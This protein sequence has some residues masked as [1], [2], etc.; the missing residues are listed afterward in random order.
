MIEIT[1]ESGEKTEIE[2]RTG[3]ERK[4]GIERRTGNGKK[5]GRDVKRGTEIG[6]K[7]AT[8]YLT[9]MIGGKVK[10]IP[11]TQRGG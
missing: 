6:W 9:K 8:K 4:T 1:I 10:D 11:R 2:R 7:E 5:T 3:I